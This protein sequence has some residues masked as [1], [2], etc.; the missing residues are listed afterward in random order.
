MQTEKQVSKK[1]ENLI[2]KSCI[3]TG[4]VWYENIVPTSQTCYIPSFFLFTGK[5]NVYKI[6]TMQITSIQKYDTT[7]KQ[8]TFT[9]NSS[10]YRT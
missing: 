1:I 2:I 10:Q 8:Y 6:T 7:I 9:C 3:Q 5:Y 4:L